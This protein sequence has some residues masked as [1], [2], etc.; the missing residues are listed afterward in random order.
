MPFATRHAFYDRL[1]DS[2]TYRLKRGGTAMQDIL[3]FML[4]HSTIFI[5]LIGYVTALT[6]VSVWHTFQKAGK[7]GWASIVPFYNII[8]WLEIAEMPLWWFLI[9]FIP[10]FNILATILINESLGKKFGKSGIF[11]AL[12]LSF[13][14]FVFYSILASPATKYKCT[15]TPPE[16]AW[17]RISK[18]GLYLT[19]LLIFC[20]FLFL[21][22]TIFQ[23]K[24]LLQLSDI[25]SETGVPSRLAWGVPA[26]LL[27]YVLLFIS[28][29]LIWKYKKW[30]VYSF[31]FLYIFYIS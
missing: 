4:I 29:I 3:N 27:I 23:I 12:G 22:D 30:G 5:P 26:F 14:P 18:M 2:V 17:P 7:P 24:F 25:F 13:L 16:H 9:M 28:T 31:V 8:V 10:G 11:G 1:P 19:A 20:F 15:D 21:Y 6:F